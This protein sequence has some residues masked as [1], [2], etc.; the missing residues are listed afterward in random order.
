[1]SLLNLCIATSICPNVTSSL[2]ANSGEI[3]IGPVGTCSAFSLCRS[4]EMNLNEFVSTYPSPL[5]LPGK[6]RREKLSPH[7][8][9]IEH[10]V[11]MHIKR[12]VRHTGR[13]WM[14]L[15]LDPAWDAAVKRLLKDGLLVEHPEL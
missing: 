15:F 13:G 2:S 12:D 5:T 11:L 14:P 8:R 9:R 7:I 10:N 4:L 3:V 6:K 1:M